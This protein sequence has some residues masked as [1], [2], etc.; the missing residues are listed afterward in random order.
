MD[1][2]TKNILTSLFWVA[3]AAVLLYFCFR[4]I[5][6]KEFGE[7]LSLCRWEYVILSMLLGVAVLYVR[8]LRWRMLFLPFDRSISAVTCFNAYNIGMVTNLA[9]PRAGELIKLAYIVKRSG[10]DAEGKHLVTFDKALGT[11]LVERLFDAVTLIVLV[12]VLFF[13]ER[14]VFSGYLS[15]SFTGFGSRTLWWLAGAAAVLLLAFLYLSYRLRDR[16]GIWGKTWEFLKGI[17]KGFVSFKDMDK[18]WLFVLYTIAIWA[19]YWIMSAAILWA[20]QDIEAFSGLTLIDAFLLMVAG[21]MSSVIPVPGGFGA[22]HGVVSG[23]L[24]G[25]W[26][27]PMG[28][29]MIYATLN[30]ESQV[31]TQALCGL[32]SY[33][34]ESFVRK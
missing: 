2:R 19:I 4:S 17:W 26:N 16:G 10:K 34:H 33:I 6:W 3:V 31:L 24:Q 20:L 30:H 18:P 28:T 5:D 11:V 21:S 32:V 25:I 7:A 14:D 9:V 15:G 22:Y 13:V 1:K 29:G 12:A 23:I 27:V 8:G